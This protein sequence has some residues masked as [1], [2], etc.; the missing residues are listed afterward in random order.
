VH[1]STPLCVCG[2]WNVVNASTSWLV[3]SNQFTVLHLVL[4]D[5]ILPVDPL[6]SVFT[7][8]MSRSH[9]CFFFQCQCLFCICFSDHFSLC[10]TVSCKKWLTVRALTGYTLH[11]Q[12]FWLSWGGWDL[13][14]VFGNCTFPAVSACIRFMNPLFISVLHSKWNC[15]ALWT[16]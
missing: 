6:T 8:G 3:I 1:R 4:M 9:F 7:S 10:I 2:M 14:P 11:M 13:W 15:Q 16:T 5:D 12:F